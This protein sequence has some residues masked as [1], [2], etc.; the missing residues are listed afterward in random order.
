MNNNEENVNSNNNNINSKPEKQVENRFEKAWDKN[1]K[2]PYICWVFFLTIHHVKINKA[3][4]THRTIH[5][6]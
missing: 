1:G 6:Y 5:I 2:R 3:C 4:W